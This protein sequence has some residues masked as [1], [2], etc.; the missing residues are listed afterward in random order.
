M[1]ASKGQVSVRASIKL[2]GRL[3]LKN[4]KKVK[5]VSGVNVRQN[6]TSRYANAVVV[7]PCIQ[8]GVV[9]ITQYTDML[10]LACSIITAH[11]N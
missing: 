8:C 5:H 11:R 6:I 4:V 3:L 2:P 7:V 9:H 1:Y 10:Q